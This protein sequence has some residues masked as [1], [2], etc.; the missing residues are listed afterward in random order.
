[1]DYKTKGIGRYDIR[2]L[3]KYFRVLFNVPEDGA[4]P[5]IET[6]DHVCEVFPG[7]NYII[8]E[9]SKLPAQTVAQ[10]FQ[11]D[12]GGYTIE[13]KEKIY[14]GAY[15]NQNGAFRGFICHEICHVF[16]FS[17]GYTPILTRSFKDIPPYCSVE[18]QAKA[19]CGEV[20]IPYENSDGM[21]PE[22]IIDKYKV[23]KSFAFVRCGIY[24]E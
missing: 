8:V 2:K 9:D 3:S 24:Y 16:L 19:L 12:S 5:V 6:L 14:N 10:C 1:M 4:F 21:S 23:S 11:N 18:W 22:E 17:I 20:M 15:K 13:I 7:S